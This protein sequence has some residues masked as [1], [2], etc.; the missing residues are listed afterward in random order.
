VL[1]ES[2][3]EKMQDLMENSRENDE[4]FIFVNK[5]LSLVAF[6]REITPVTDQHWVARRFL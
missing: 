2:K 5:K 4:N 6:R 1:E 3:K